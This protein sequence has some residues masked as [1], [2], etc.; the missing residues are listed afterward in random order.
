ML[1]R[2]LDSTIEDAIKMQAD[3]KFGEYKALGDTGA[4]KK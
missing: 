2:T 1:T 3:K 4:L